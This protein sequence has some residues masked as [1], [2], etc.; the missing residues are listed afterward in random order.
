MSLCPSMRVPTSLC[1]QD[2][3]R[4]TV[5]FRFTCAESQGKK[6]P[7][8]CCAPSPRTPPMRC[9]ATPGS[10]RDSWRLGCLVPRG[11]RGQTSPPHGNNSTSKNHR[12]QQEQQQQEQKRPLQC[13]C[14]RTQQ[15]QTTAEVAKN[16][17]TTAAQTSQQQKLTT[18]T[19]G[20]SAVTATTAHRFIGHGAAALRKSW[21][22]TIP[23]QPITCRATYYRT[24][25]QLQLTDLGTTQQVPYSNYY[26]VTYRID[27]QNQHRVTA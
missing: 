15:P 16:A 13:P 14:T 9:G 17:N 25:A 26:R 2:L 27:I 3:A 1:V 20:D 4:C 11:R 6:C 18:A 21:R 12:Q 23:N 5:T 8:S 7:P 10:Q 19:R 24:V 22:P